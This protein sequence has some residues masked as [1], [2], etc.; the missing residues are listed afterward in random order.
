[1]L[2]SNGNICCRWQRGG[3][4][5][6]SVYIEKKQFISLTDCADRPIL[7]TPA[8]CQS[9]LSAVVSFQPFVF[10]IPPSWTNRS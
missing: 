7:S 5:V 6:G 4:F 2:S 3:G 1:M 9:L 8:G 10:L